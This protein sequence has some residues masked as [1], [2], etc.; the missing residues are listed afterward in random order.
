MHKVIWTRPTIN[1]IGKCW[2]VQRLQTIA[3][4]HH[5]KA[6]GGKG[7]GKPPKP[8]CR[9]QIV[10]FNSSKKNKTKTKQTKNSTSTLSAQKGTK[11]ELTKLGEKK[12][13]CTRETVEWAG[14]ALEITCLYG[15]FK[16]RARRA[17]SDSMVAKMMH[18]QGKSISHALANIQCWN[19]QEFRL[20]TTRKTGVE[21][22]VLT[23]WEKSNWKEHSF[24]EAE[25]TAFQ[26][27]LMLNNVIINASFKQWE[28]SI[29]LIWAPG[30]TQSP[31]K[32]GVVAI[33][34][35][36]ITSAPVTASWAEEQTL[37][38]PLTELANFTAFSLV[39]FHILTFKEE[40]KKKTNRLAW[41]ISPCWSRT[42]F[43]FSVDNYMY[44]NVGL[45]Y[46]FNVLVMQVTKSYVWA[47]TVEWL[48]CDTRITAPCRDVFIKYKYFQ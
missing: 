11:E 38:G 31:N 4:Q 2:H 19:M 36:I 41:R 23:I 24:W 42:S 22:V 10:K 43:Q 30:F 8:H 28:H 26:Q 39:R 16:W 7:G 18:H 14:I 1:K 46:P 33:V 3:W 5:H 34:T 12:T 40:K 29:P 9:G 20:Q 25:S 6:G 48:L 47:T 35:V 21:K 27:F 15:L 45:F 44:L 17:S 13:I 37:T 32:I